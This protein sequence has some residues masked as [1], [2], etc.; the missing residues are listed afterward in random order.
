M[1]IV[2]NMGMISADTYRHYRCP[3]YLERFTQL[4]LN[5]RKARAVR[6]NS[7]LQWLFGIGGRPLRIL[8]NPPPGANGVDTYP[9]VRWWS[10]GGLVRA[11]KRNQL[12]QQDKSIGIAELADAI[13]NCRP[14]FPPHDFTLHL[15]ELT[16]AIQNAG[17]A[18][19][20]TKLETSFEPL[21]PRPET[22]AAARD[23][24]AAGK[25]SRLLKAVDDR[26]VRMHRH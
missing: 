14:S 6:N 2:G 24:S 8:R 7:L 23:Y 13:E 10:P 12:G 9:R 18:S 25:P 20:A 26:L 11:L 22:L 21:Q 15:T 3:V 19:G 1:R 5:A 16:I 4:T 17:T